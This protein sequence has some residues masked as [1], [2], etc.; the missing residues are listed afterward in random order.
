MS[1]AR[2]LSRAR[3]AAQLDDQLV[4]LAEAGGPDRV[5]LRDQSARGIYRQAAADA[6][7]ASLGEPTTSSILAKPEILDLDDLAHR[8]GVVDLSDVDVLRADPSLLVCAGRR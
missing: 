5:P 4:N 1:R 3:L 6:S 2:D 7:L 8:G